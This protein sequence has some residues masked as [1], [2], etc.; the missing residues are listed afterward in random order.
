[1]LSYAAISKSSAESLEFENRSLKKL[2][3]ALEKALLLS[4]ELFNRQKSA[5]EEI[6]KLSEIQEKAATTRQFI[7]GNIAGHR[8]RKKM[9]AKR[10]GDAKNVVANE[11]RQQIKDAWASGKYSSRGVCSEEECAG[12]G[13]AYGVARKAL[14]NTPDPNPWPAK[15]AKN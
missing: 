11:K 10:G 6:D 3:G 12:I 2:L 8:A 5:H 15:P 7:E 14:N 1:M 13:M 4:R 9:V